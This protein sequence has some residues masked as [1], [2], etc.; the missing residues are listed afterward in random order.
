MNLTK[1]YQVLRVSSTSEKWPNNNCKMADQVCLE[2]QKILINE[3]IT[4]DRKTKS[5]S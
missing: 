4:N 2:N 5:K 3:K 1:M